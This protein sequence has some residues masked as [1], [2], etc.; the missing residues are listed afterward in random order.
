ME[1]LEKQ[2]V[3]VNIEV[4]VKDD[5]YVNMEVRVKIRVRVK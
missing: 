5:E 1:D 4:R 2:S 3:R